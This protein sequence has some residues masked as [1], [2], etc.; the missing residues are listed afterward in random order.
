MKQILRNDTFQEKYSEMDSEMSSCC[1]FLLRLWIL[2]Q[3]A[4]HARGA[5]REPPGLGI[6]RSLSLAGHL[7][8]KRFLGPWFSPTYHQNCLKTEPP[9]LKKQTFA[10]HVRPQCLLLFTTLC[11]HGASQGDPKG[12]PEPH[13]ENN[14]FSNRKKSPHKVQK[15]VQMGDFIS[16]VGALGRSWGIFGGTVRFLT[17]QIQP[18]CS[19]NGIKGAKVTPKGCHRLPKWHQ[20]GAKIT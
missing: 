15:G 16:G 4:A 7:F 5:V 11:R 6:V 8:L 20:N 3:K 17:Q 2:V 14:R 18:K 1:C 10:Q 19:Q 12:A 9:S 13:Q